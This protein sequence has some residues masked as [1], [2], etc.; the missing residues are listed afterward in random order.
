MLLH[1]LGLAQIRSQ[2]PA[3]DSLRLAAVLAPDNSRYSYIYGIAL[4][5]EGKSDQALEILKGALGINP[6]DRDLLIALVTINRD[7]G[8]LVQARAFA[9]QLVTFYPQDATARQLLNSL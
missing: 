1:S 7:R 4:N 9:Q 3:L 2:K 5:S 6:N 8:E